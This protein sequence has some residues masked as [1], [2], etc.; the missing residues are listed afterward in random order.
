MINASGHHNVESCVFPCVHSDNSSDFGWWIKTLSG[1]LRLSS[2]QS[3]WVQRQADSIYRRDSAFDCLFRSPRRQSR[4]QPKRRPD[5]ST[6]LFRSMQ[7]IPS[8]SGDAIIGV[9]NK[10]FVNSAKMPQNERFRERMELSVDSLDLMISNFA[11]L[12]Q[13][14]EVIESSSVC[15]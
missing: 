6:R 13:T 2:C 11:V 14:F 8:P 1:I 5:V 12:K 3:C 7:T 10:H 4:D 9:M 15:L